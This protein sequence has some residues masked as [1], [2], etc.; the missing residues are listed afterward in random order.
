VRGASALA[1]YVARGM[2]VVGFIM[3]LL[4]WNGAAGLDYIQ[5]QFPYLLSGAMPGLALIITGVG[6]EY[7]QAQRQLTAKRAQQM[8]ELNVAMLHLVSTL[9]E[10]GGITPT[11]D[12]PEEAVTPIAGPGLAALDV[13]GSAFHAP[14][15]AATATQVQSP[16][17]DTADEFVVA[18]RSSFHRADCHLVAG[19]DDMATITRLEAEAKSLTACRVCKP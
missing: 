14:T 13:A 1:T 16:K 6:L 11:A 4:A 15:A 17:T 10:H 18:G 3:I 7:V 8:A 2:V 19:R 12:T 5:G 9:K